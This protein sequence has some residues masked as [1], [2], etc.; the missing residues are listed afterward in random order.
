[1]N[2]TTFQNNVRRR[3]GFRTDLGDAILDELNQVIEGA[4]Q[5]PRLGS[6]WFLMTKATGT[7]SSGTLTLPNQFKRLWDS[8]G[9]LWLNIDNLWTQIYRDT[10]DVLQGPDYN[11][12]G[13]PAYF[14][15]TNS[16]LEIR[17]RPAIEYSYE[18]YYI[19]GTDSVTVDNGNA[20][21]WLQNAGPFCVEHVTMNLAA[22]IGYTEAEARATREAAKLWAALYA[23]NIQF[24]E[25]TLDR[26]K[27][28]LD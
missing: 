21:V 4:T 13:T 1:M 15:Q 6:P 8:A 12:D 23:E 10:I 25:Q 11:I 5:D 2:F 24:E 16:A 20:S 17:P 28:G 22:A 19:T 14:F 9:G 7:I 26:M 3:L 18:F 27:G